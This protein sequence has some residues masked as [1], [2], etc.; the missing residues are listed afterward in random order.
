MFP[1]ENFRVVTMS[2]DDGKRKH[3]GGDGKGGFNS[4]KMRDE[5][6]YNEVVSS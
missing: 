6:R 4:Q 2:E 1:N 3:Q 5:R